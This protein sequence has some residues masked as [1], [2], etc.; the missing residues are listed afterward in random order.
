VK[1]RVAKRKD[2]LLRV[3]RELTKVAAETARQGDGI[4]RNQAKRLRGEA[5]SLR[6]RYAKGE[7]WG[8]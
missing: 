8:K 7:R 1:P 2:R 3:A 4:S 5:S 6:H